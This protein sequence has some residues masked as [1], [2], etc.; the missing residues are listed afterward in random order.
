MATS[1]HPPITCSGC[2]HSWTGTAA[3]HCGSC[4]HTFSAPRTFDLHRGQY[5]ER[6]QC[7]DPEEVRSR[8]G[9]RL[10]FLR[11]GMWRGPEMTEAQKAARFGG[12]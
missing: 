2:D 6:G 10:L 12:R 4:H 11:D 5:G 9:D 3:A 7:L 1:V 8:S